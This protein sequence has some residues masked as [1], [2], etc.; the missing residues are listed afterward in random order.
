MMAVALVVALDDK[1]PSMEILEHIVCQNKKRARILI[2][3][4]E[5]IYKY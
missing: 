4:I 1:Y 5:I 3:S 2:E